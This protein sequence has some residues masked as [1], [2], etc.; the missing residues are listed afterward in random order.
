LSRNSGV[1]GAGGIS[2]RKIINCGRSVAG[3]SDE[4]LEGRGTKEA[5]LKGGQGGSINWG[6]ALGDRFLR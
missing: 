4:T 1:L 5:T 6:W 2:L 3:R